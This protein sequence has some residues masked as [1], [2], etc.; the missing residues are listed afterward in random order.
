MDVVRVSAEEVK[1]R[2]DGGEALTIVDVRSATDFDSEHI[3][4]AR[5]LSVKELPQRFG[6]L[7]KDRT[8]MCY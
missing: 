5:S 6:E 8:I 7:P 3:A 4:G 2:L 1:R